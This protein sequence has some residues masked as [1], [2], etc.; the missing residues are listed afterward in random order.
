[1]KF[2]YLGKKRL[3]S[4]HNH[5]YGFFFPGDD[6]NILKRFVAGKELLTD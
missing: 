3:V 5:F 6:R 2:L 4:V 1:M